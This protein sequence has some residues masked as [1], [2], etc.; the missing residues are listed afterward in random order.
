MTF[1]LAPKFGLHIMPYAVC[2]FLIGFLMPWP[3]GTCGK[4]I[5]TEI[6]PENARASI[7]AAQTLVERCAG[8]LGGITVGY[9]A[10]SWYAYDLQAAKHTI[11]D[12]SSEDRMNNA[13][14]LGNAML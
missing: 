10:Q 2:V 13:N 11:A 12:M 4:V 14:A 8:S 9:V 3:G 5:F 1:M 7:V 6:V